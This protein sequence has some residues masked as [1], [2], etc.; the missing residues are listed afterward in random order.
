MATDSLVFPLYE[1]INGTELNITYR[2][3]NIVP[4]RD[5]LGVQPRFKHLFKPENE[6]LIDEWQKRVDEKWVY[7]Q[8]REEARV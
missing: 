7:L 3:K 8:K 5:Y 1:V 2:P 4:V 6:Y